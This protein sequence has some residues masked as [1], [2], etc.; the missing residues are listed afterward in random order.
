MPFEVSDDRDLAPAEL[1]VD[2][3][4]YCMLSTF[5]NEWA[6]RSASRYSTVRSRSTL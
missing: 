4:G 6:L 3:A 5:V 2:F 1:T